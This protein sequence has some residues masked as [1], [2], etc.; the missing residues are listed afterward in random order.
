ML[1]SPIWSFSAFSAI[2]ETA[3]VNV[4]SIA[5]VYLLWSIDRDGFDL[6]KW[7]VGGDEAEAA[8]GD[9]R[10]D[11]AVSIRRGV[12]P[13]DL[14][15]ARLVDALLRTTRHRHSV[16]IGRMRGKGWCAHLREVLGSVARLRNE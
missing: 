12:G 3:D 16:S 8:L 15:D 4:W 11:E 2:A 5:R 6:T 1:I 13:K 9:L 10:G 7:V 14:Q